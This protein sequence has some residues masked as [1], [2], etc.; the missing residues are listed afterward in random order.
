[1]DILPPTP[2][3]FSWPEPQ[4][5]PPPQPDN[6]DIL[7][8]TPALFSWPQPQQSPPPNGPLVDLSSW[9]PL[10]LP[11]P[12]TTVT[13]TIPTVPAVT[14]EERLTEINNWR[15]RLTTIVSDDFDLDDC[16]A[17]GVIPAHVAKVL[18]AERD[19]AAAAAAYEARLQGTGL[20]P[21]P[22]LHAAAF[23]GTGPLRPGVA[24]PDLA[25]DAI[26]VAVTLGGSKGTTTVDAI[27]DTGAGLSMIDLA[28]AETLCRH[29]DAV[30]VGHRRIGLATANGTRTPD[31]Y[32]I[33]RVDV[34]PKSTTPAHVASTV[35][36]DCVALQD[37][38]VPLLIGTPAMLI[39]GIDV[40]FSSC[41]ISWPCVGGGRTLIGF[42]CSDSIPITRNENSAYLAES[43]LSSPTISELT[44]GD[45]ATPADASWLA[46]AV[47]EAGLSLASSLQA[48]G[49]AS[50]EYT[51]KLKI[52]PDATPSFR[53][54]YNVPAALRK[55]LKDSLDDM[56]A[57]GIIAPTRSNWGH[58]MICLLKKKTLEEGGGARGG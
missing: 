53:K 45:A 54:H 44:T 40:F 33:Y 34:E 8:P 47:S 18:V 29:R 16:V 42:S 7:P 25:G 27:L 26:R 57:S 19:V 31:L 3:L 17:D 5:S 23:D 30:Y 24:N 14:A 38:P 12:T 6:V 37:L 56:V 39:S 4:Q 55:A 32:P 52:R 46:R 21:T 35:T 41:E 13:A 9:P 58:P 1:M 28:M 11:S 50:E 51:V 36:V 2:A 43:F 20:R 49:A 22:V 48:T 15:S 10:P